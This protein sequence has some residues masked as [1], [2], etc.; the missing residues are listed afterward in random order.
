MDDQEAAITPKRT[1]LE[2]LAYLVQ[3]GASEATLL[4]CQGLASMVLEELRASEEGVTPGRKAGLLKEVLS[5]IADE[6]RRLAFSQVQQIPTSR[7]C[8]EITCFRVAAAAELIRLTD[9]AVFEPFKQHRCE[10]FTSTWAELLR[11]AGKRG[12][13]TERQL[14][15]AFWLGGRSA[16]TGFLFQQQAPAVLEAAIRGHLVSE[17][18]RADLIA[19]FVDKADN[20]SLSMMPTST[21]VSGESSPS[22]SMVDT[23]LWPTRPIDPSRAA[24]EEALPPPTG[25]PD[26]PTVSSLPKGRNRNKV[27]GA[28]AALAVAAGAA[29]A[30]PW[31]TRSSS[32]P[33][34][35]KVLNRYP[36][37]TPR[38]LEVSKNVHIKPDTI[39]GWALPTVRAPQTLDPAHLPEVISPSV[40]GDSN[41][42]DTESDRFNAWVLQRGG[43]TVGVTHLRVVLSAGAQPIQ[44][45]NICARI[46]QR[47]PA[48]SGTLFFKTIAG[49]QSML[50]ALNLDAAAPCGNYFQNR[51]LPIGVRQ[52]QH[53]DI[54][55]VSRIGTVTWSLY[56]VISVNGSLKTVQID[57]GRPLRTTA[58]LQDVLQYGAYYEYQA[59]AGGGE[60]VPSALDYAGASGIEKALSGQ[61]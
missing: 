58:V 57:P 32:P 10:Q 9:E 50:T 18:V 43:A 36:T 23:G 19:R 37:V 35:G 61:H 1:A 12:P 30:V 41:L 7:E 3:V 39:D 51:P 59:G 21:P 47:G 53:V 38:L 42:E 28:A 54:D 20:A 24:S 8:A 14:R 5:A 16:R 49:D 6:Q 56:A 29:V 45:Q 4:E 60:F 40:T 11:A 26:L 48:L 22:A 25:S 13:A 33:L 55:A 44:V 27:I 2:D 34:T 52:V 31:N 15:A 46:I 17:D